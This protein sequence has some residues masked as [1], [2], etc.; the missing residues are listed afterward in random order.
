MGSTSPMDDSGLAKETSPKKD[1]TEF[2]PMTWSLKEIRAAIPAHLFLRDTFHGLRFLTRDV[3]LAAVIWKAGTCIDPLC[4]RAELQVAITGLG[5]EVVRW[6][7]WS[8]Y[9]WFQGL[10]FTGIWVI[11]HECGHGA[12]SS[13]Q[14]ICDVIGFISHS[15]LWTPYFSWKISHHRHHKSHASMER[16]EVYV[17][18]TRSDLGL[19]RKDSQDIDWED[20]FGDTP[21]YTL[22]VLVRQ[23]LLAFPA[24]LLFNVSGQK[25]YPPWTN[26]FNPNSVLFTKGQAS[27]VLLSNTGLLLAAICL[28]LA[29]KQWGAIAVIKYYGIPWLLVTHWFIMITFLHH[30]DP[31]LPH[32]RGKAWNYQRGAAATVDRNFLGWQ[33]RFFLHD[34]AHFHVVHHFFPKMPFYHGPEATMH[35]KA[36][37]G[38]HYMYSD[39]PIFKALWDNYN[40]CQFVEDEGSVLFYRDRTGKAIRRPAAPYATA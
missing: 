1:A 24:Y 33:G 22:L 15:F 5:A 21:I 30:T 4:Q 14:R 6:I 34:V 12:F 17:P 27:L 2:Q 31:L 32:Y 3:L 7:A 37:I 13:S 38:E 23:Q 39:K 18:K 10:V 25:E 26:H 8:T 20:Y 40:S 9:W 35:L 29:C 28:R 11:G 36:F 16:D 19:P